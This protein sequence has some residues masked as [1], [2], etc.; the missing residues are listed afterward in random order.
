MKRPLVLLAAALLGPASASA[1][2]S[3]FL[4]D[5]L[6]RHLVNEISGDRAYESLRQLTRWHRTPASRDY[7]A[8]AE[9]VRQAAEAA[10]L[11]GVRLI[12]QKWKHKG[13]TCRS[14]EA[15]LPSRLVAG[16]R[17]AGSASRRG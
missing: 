3:P 8:A 10:G 9:W 16:S 12:R 15:W 14:G 7:F 5:P 17:H 13:W 11:E 1:Q 4:P 2:T 6:H